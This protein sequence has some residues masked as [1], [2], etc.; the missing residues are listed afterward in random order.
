MTIRGNAGLSVPDRR[1][2]AIAAG[3]A[4][5][6][7]LLFLWR[8]GDP[9]KLNFDETH[10]VPAARML[11]T[12]EG[13]PNPEHPPLGKLLIALGMALLGDGPLGWRVPGALFGAITV[14]AGTMAT[15]WLLL[16]GPAAWMAGLLMILSQTLFVEA[17]TAMLDI[18]MAGFLMLAFWQFVAAART[19][20]TYRRHL[21][22][23]SAFMGLSLACKWTVIPIMAV[24]L[25]ILAYLFWRETKRS[26]KIDHADKAGAR[27]PLSL[28]EAAGWVG[29]F[30]A[31]V[32]LATF[33]PY[34]FLRHDAVSLAGILPQQIEMLR[35]QR[36]P[37]AGHPYQS[38]WWQWVLN[39]RPIW[40]FYEPVAGVQRGVLMIG[41]PVICWGGLVALAA[42]LRVG[43][44]DR[45][46]P[47]LVPVLLW[48]APLAFFALAPK[49]VQFYYHYFP[50]SLMLCIAIGAV[51]DHCSARRSGR[52]F[53]WL[54]LGLAALVFLEFYPIISAMPLGDPQDFNRW[55]WI[56]SWR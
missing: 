40:F 36:S 24:S 53:A 21:V 52:V 6:A 17:R 37:M 56:E 28:Q 41:N 42:S 46:W 12:L 55:M 27:R 3:L 1:D 25:P 29:P 2:V 18:F 32:Y 19:G 39:L 9:A 14:F 11:L 34:L 48:A 45:A 15:R 8:I 16:R 49:A 54:T 22:L 10:Y 4:L 20:F 26:V 33:L 44:R 38:H 50:S 13:L 5:A 43:L 47:L 31:L 51:L 35:L 23:G 7:L 30:A